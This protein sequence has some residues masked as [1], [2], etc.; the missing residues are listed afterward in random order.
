MYNA[1]SF[2]EL[3]NSIINFRDSYPCVRYVSLL[4]IKDHCIVIKQGYLKKTVYIPITF[5]NIK[6]DI[7]K[8]S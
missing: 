2:D 4:N 3:Y 6:V 1:T 7:I 5:N 8:R